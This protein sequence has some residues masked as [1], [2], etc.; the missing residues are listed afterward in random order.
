MKAILNWIKNNLQFIIG[1]LILIIVL[2]FL[3]QI[4]YKNIF[5]GISQSVPIQFKI[6]SSN[7]IFFPVNNSSPEITD[8]FDISKNTSVTQILTVTDD[9]SY[10]LTISK[11]TYPFIVYVYSETIVN[12]LMYLL[13]NSDGRSSSL[14]DFKFTYDSNAKPTNGSSAKIV[15]SITISS[16]NPT[17]S[18]SINLIFYL[19][20][21]NLDSIIINSIYDHDYDSDNTSIVLNFSK[22]S[23]NSTNIVIYDK[24]NSIKDTFNS[25]DV[26]PFFEK[27]L[28]Y[29]FPNRVLE[30]D[31]NK[32]HSIYFQNDTEKP[33]FMYT[34]SDSSNN[35]FLSGYIQDI[36]KNVNYPCI[37]KI[38]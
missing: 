30:K 21:K 2:S 37:A 32:I 34:D 16:S 23:K 1:C 13:Q 27:M 24:N 14:S 8:L 25:I 6:N 15:L 31:N 7:S 35:R 3:Y 22:N 20:D 12:S 10:S 17:L 9:L 19:L 36:S 28:L 38:L 5:E 4:Y 26:I 18:S 11:T 33:L 29:F